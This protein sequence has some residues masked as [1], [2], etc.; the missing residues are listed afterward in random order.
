MC[1]QHCVFTVIFTHTY[2]YTYSLLILTTSD[3][4]LDVYPK[5]QEDLVLQT[6]ILKKSQAG[7]VSLGKTSH[8]CPWVFYVPSAGAQA[9]Q[10]SVCHRVRLCFLLLVGT[11]IYMMA[12]SSPPAASYISFPTSH[13]LHSKMLMIVVPAPKGCCA[14]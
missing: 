11:Q 3:I 13:T 9:P 4:P 14:E 8:H 2:T 6:G 10:V 7:P 12:P 5:V 1:V